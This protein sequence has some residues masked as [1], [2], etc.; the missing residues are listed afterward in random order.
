MGYEVPLEFARHFIKH[1]LAL[2]SDGFVQFSEQLRA[3]CRTAP[4]F[5]DTINIYLAAG[6]ERRGKVDIFWRFF[7]EL[8]E[9]L[10][11][12][13]VEI[14]FDRSRTGNVNEKRKLVR[15]MLKSDISWQPVD[16][17]NQN[18]ALG[19][20]PILRFVTNAGKNPDVFEALA[21]LM[22]YFPAIFF[23]PG[24]RILAKHQKEEGGTRLLA[25]VNTAFYLERA[26]QRF[27]QFD[28]TGPLPRTIYESCL[29]LLDAVV[30]T[31]SARAY[32]LREHLVRSRKII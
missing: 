12:V 15:N 2:D 32:Y 17:E 5:L 20:E 7:S 29:V 25:G 1:L 22:H 28:S 27:L 18:I 21:K 14:A 10:Q 16:F 24:T 4:S 30:E 9:T 23:E 26:I 19:K 3:A 8:S 31:A 11:D 13:A 6:A